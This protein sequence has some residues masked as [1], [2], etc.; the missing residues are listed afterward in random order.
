MRIMGFSDEDVNYVYDKN[1]G[2][3]YYCGKRLSFVNYGKNGKRGSWHIDHSKAR[4]RGGS[5]YRRNL[6]PSCIVCNLDKSTLSGSHYKRKFEPKTFGGKFNEF[7]SLSP[8]T[9][10]ASRRKRMK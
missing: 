10:G 9:F 2:Y 8:G 7:F 5:D 4:A 1:N 3:C 6:V